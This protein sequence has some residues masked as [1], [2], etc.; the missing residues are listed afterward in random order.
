MIG[1]NDHIQGTLERTSCIEEEEFCESLNPDL[2]GAP[3]WCLSSGHRI[4]SYYDLF[5]Y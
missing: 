1:T 4:M 3:L 5:I 2:P